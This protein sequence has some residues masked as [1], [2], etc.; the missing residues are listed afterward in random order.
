MRDSANNF[1]SNK[2]PQI[3][4]GSG[5]HD[6]YYNM[7]HSYE[8]RV[9]LGGPEVDIFSRKNSEPEGNS[10]SDKF[11][12]GLKPQLISRNEHKDG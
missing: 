9:G 1:L 12:N 5:Y 8:A 6:N 10:Y 3:P 2:I 7:R 11:L 4:S